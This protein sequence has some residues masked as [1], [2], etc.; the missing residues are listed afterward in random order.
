MMLLCYIIFGCLIFVLFIYS[1]F[2]VH[3]FL[4]ASL[5]VF[6]ARISR[7]KTHLLSETMIQGKHYFHYVF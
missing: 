4:R 3:Y 6:L 1:F 5:C 2:E 7:K